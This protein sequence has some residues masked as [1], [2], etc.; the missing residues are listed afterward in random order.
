MIGLTGGGL[1][2]TECDSKGGGSSGNRQ[3]KVT[4]ST[5]IVV[6]VELEVGLDRYSATPVVEDL[7]KSRRQ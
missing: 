5:V 3:K 7:P 6:V 4:S 2:E 1:P